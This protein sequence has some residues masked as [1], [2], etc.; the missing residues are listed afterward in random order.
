MGLREI[1]FRAFDPNTN[2]F[3]YEGFN[4]FG[5]ITLYD[6]IRGYSLKNSCE[7]IITQFIGLKDKDGK[8]IYEGDIIKQGDNPECWFSPRV[9]EFK[10]GQWMGND[11]RL[12]VD[13]ERGL[14]QGYVNQNNWE[15]IG[16]IYE[17]SE[18]LND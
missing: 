7:L 9:V 12:Y 14:Y 16:N 5:E 3:I 18:T 17:K 10:D 2:K 13:Q 15:I 11:C 1:K 8:D 4:I 6:V